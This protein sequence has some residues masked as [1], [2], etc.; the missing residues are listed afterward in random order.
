MTG[1]VRAG[2]EDAVI[3]RQKVNIVKNQTVEIPGLHGFRIAN[4]KIHRPVEE[5]FVILGYHKY[6][7]IQKYVPKKL[8]FVLIIGQTCN[9]CSV[10][11]KLDEY[12]AEI[13]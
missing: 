3:L 1:L 7:R 6:S 11:S 4:V 10:S 9:E 2:V 5:L 13:L 8:W 12:G